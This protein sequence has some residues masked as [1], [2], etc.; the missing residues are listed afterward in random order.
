MINIALSQ[1]GF[2]VGPKHL[3][4]YYLPYS[5]GCLWAHAKQ[6]PDIRNNSK[7]VEWIF[8]RDN[9][10]SMINKWDRLDVLI[11]SMYIWNEKYHQHLSKLVKQKWP[12]CII[13]WGGPQCD[14]SKDDIFEKQPYVDLIGVSEGEITFRE[15][16][17]K[18]I[19]EEDWRNVDGNV[20]ND[21]LIPRRTQGRPRADLKTLASPYIEGVFDE[22]IKNNPEYTWSGTLETNRGCP[23]ACTYCDW[24]QLTASKVKQFEELKIEK[25]VNWFSK[26][27][28]SW[29]GIADANFGIFKKRDKIIA[30]K[31]RD[32]HDKTGYPE[33]CGITTLKN[34]NQTAL[35]IVE[36]FGPKLLHNGLTLS[37]QS[38]DRHTLEII[39]RSNMKTNDFA[40]IVRECKKR[41]LK[42]YTEM[43]MPLPGESLKSF[44]KGYF[45]LYENDIHEGIDVYPLMLSNNTEMRLDQKEENE[46]RTIDVPLNGQ[47][48][49]QEHTE[50]MPNVIA[51]RTM[52]Y[53]DYIKATWFSLKQIGLHQ[54]GYSLNSSKWAFENNVSYQLFYDQLDTTLEK[55][56]EW[57]TFKNKMI[58][59]LESY[60]KFDGDSKFVDNHH[61]E[62]LKHPDKIQVIEFVISCRELIFDAIKET[63]EYF[64]C[65]LTDHIIQKSKAIVYDVNNPHQWPMNVNGTVHKYVGDKISDKDHYIEFLMHRRQKIWVNTM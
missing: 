39:R 9:I 18:I 29:M 63:L 52:P 48:D 50:Y 28:I 59:W 58:N 14:H 34:S 65:E 32:T 56:N 45:S 15:T 61:K 1:V 20:Y 57:R 49:N 30:Q 27:K 41:N 17:L 35:E 23:Y 16:I 12:N 47:E 4:N 5:V 43:I 19:N 6:E 54:I 60:Y 38:T 44:V 64:N 21:N 33:H 7:I 55:Y 10:E 37:I 26:N 31:I 62:L 40:D 36:I 24:G 42:Y 46:L 22:I 51:T 13:M 2:R 8:K 3:K 11:C 25:E 53:N